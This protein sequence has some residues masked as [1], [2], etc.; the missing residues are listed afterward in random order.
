[1]VWYFLCSPITEYRWNTSE[2]SECTR[3]CG[4]GSRTRLVTCL[5]ISIPINST[6]IAQLDSTIET[7]VNETMCWMF[8]PAGWKPRSRELCNKETCPIWQTT[9][10]YSEVSYTSLPNTFSNPL[11]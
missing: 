3:S 7:E 5:N 6:Y 9:E 1:M 11:L 2:W 8:E 4:G 10:E